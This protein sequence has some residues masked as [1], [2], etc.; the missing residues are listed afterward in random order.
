MLPGL[1]EE[2]VAEN[3]LNYEGTARASQTQSRGGR[4]NV[5][6]LSSRLVFAQPEALTGGMRTLPPHPTPPQK[7]DSK[8]QTWSTAQAEKHKGNNSRH[9]LILIRDPGMM[10]FDQWDVPGRPPNP[11]MKKERLYSSSS[12]RVS[13]LLTIVRWAEAWLRESQL[14]GAAL[15]WEQWELELAQ[16]QHPSTLL[17]QRLEVS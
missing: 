15:Q 9:F 2:A 17:S 4:G 6:S 12:S 11:D 14:P 16:Q 7:S 13:E 5:F 3:T 8:D 1:H 10:A